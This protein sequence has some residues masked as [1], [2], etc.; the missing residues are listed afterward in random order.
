MGNA[1]AGTVVVGA[2][3][4]DVLTVVGRLVGNTDTLID[5][6]YDGAVVEPEVG[7]RVGDIDG[8][9]GLT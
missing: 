5:G 9:V 1:V 6:A 2:M 7:D 8:S 3:D 4:N